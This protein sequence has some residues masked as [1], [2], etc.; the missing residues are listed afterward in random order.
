MHAVHV[1]RYFHSSFVTGC[2]I[3]EIK[4]YIRS[5]RRFIVSLLNVPCYSTLYENIIIIIIIITVIVK[6]KE[7]HTRGC[8]FERSATLSH[9]SRELYTKHYRPINYLGTRAISRQMASISSSK[10]TFEFYHER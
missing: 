4:F 9:V 3:T 10:L 6:K 5:R 1:I 8:Y 2:K 7:K